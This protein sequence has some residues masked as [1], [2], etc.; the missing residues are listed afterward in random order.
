MILGAGPGGISAGD[1][2]N[3]AFLVA[4]AGAAI[5][6]VSLRQIWNQ[7]K[8]DPKQA[9]GKFQLSRD[10]AAGFTLWMIGANTHDYGRYEN[11]GLVNRRN[12]NGEWGPYQDLRYQE[13]ERLGFPGGLSGAIWMSASV[14]HF[15]DTRRR[16]RG[17]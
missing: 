10:M 13:P 16:E 5:L 9:Y 8:G 14:R 3:H 15:W 12:A 6:T 11:D 17:K 2:E 1:D 7:R 4:T